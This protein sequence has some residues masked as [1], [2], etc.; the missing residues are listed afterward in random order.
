MKT[1]RSVVLIKKQLQHI[2]IQSISLGLKQG[3]MLILDSTLAPSA[4]NVKS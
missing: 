2:S 4:V 3:I 1:T